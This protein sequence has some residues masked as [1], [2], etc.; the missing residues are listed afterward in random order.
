MTE[1][2]V[3]KFVWLYMSAVAMLIV[4]S[5]SDSGNRFGD[6]PCKLRGDGNW[7]LISTD[8]DVSMENEMKHRPTL[9]TCGRFWAQNS[10]GYWELFDVKEPTRQIGD[11]E[12]RYVTHFYDDKAL[13][14]ERDKP[15]TVID[16]DG[17]IVHDFEKIGSET[18]SRFINIADGMAVW[19]VDTLHGVVSFDG[20]E[21]IPAKYAYICTPACGRIVAHDSKFAAFLESNP[22]T[23]PESVATVFDYKGDKIFTVSSRKYGRIAGRFM[24][25]YLPVGKV[26]DGED[27][28]GLLDESGEL[29]VKPSEKNRAI[30]DVMSGHYIFKNGEG[31]CG[32]R[33]ISDNSLVLKAR[34]ESARF[35]DGEHLVVS[36]KDE[37]NSGEIYYSIIGLDGEKVIGRKFLNV[38]PFFSGCLF[39]QTA[40]RRWELIDLNGDILGEHP[41]LEDVFFITEQPSPMV[42][43]DY[44]DI[45][46]MI[47]AVKMTDDGADGLTF[48]STVRQAL[49]RQARYYSYTNKPVA[50]NY[51]YTDEVN[52]FP[53]VEGE[54]VALTVKFPSNLSH[55]TYRQ[56]RVIDYVWGNYYWYHTDNIPAGYVF[57]S[58]HPVSFSVTF[59]NYGKLR[60]KLRQLYGALVKYFKQYGAVADSNTGATV[61][62]LSGGRS[63]VITLESNSVKVTWGEL[64]FSEKAIYSYDGNRE[65]LAGIFYEE[66][67]YEESEY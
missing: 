48:R 3:V 12:Y 62:D 8:G 18:P 32:V 40:D 19:S 21:V 7:S 54:S 4:S 28:W 34:Y 46:R 23:V 63:A 56:E 52:I 1:K 44:I 60:G 45:D 11:R 22:D 49:E 61:I 2:Y 35:L 53:T 20:E 47:K 39:V 26:E 16:R 13:V 31:K 30:E 27:C 57:T 41:A 64:S 6:F 51:S 25:G 38:S 65:S 66:V 43:S 37:A 10:H 14:A 55:Q 5:C 29:V 33:S 17:N 50:A 9:S 42:E 24:D 59:N 36:L 67:N 15:V 58:E